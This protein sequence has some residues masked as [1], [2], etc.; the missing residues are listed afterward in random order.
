MNSPMK[1]VKEKV[2]LFSGND[3]QILTHDYLVQT[4]NVLTLCSERFT[5]ESSAHK[6][7]LSHGFDFNKLYGKGL[8]YYKGCD[9]A[10]SS[11]Y[12]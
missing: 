7:L 9:R 2:F 12:F 10:V 3:G 4:F 11:V 6:F 5:V 1:T 8:Q